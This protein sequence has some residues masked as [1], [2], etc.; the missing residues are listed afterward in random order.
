M[1]ISDWSS[2]VCASDLRTG[3]HPTNRFEESLTIR[4]KAF[5]AGAYE[6]P[7]R[8]I[9]DRPI[10]QVHADVAVG[11]LADAVLSMGDVDGYFCPGAAPGFGGF[12]M[13]AYLGLQ[14]SYIDTTETGRSSHMV[15][16]HGST[17][18]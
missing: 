9:P 1:R 15:N 11:A 8:V 14:L 10:A 16:E 7:L 13:A 4:G 2:D 6:H 5:I 17:T 12:S 18:C 3:T